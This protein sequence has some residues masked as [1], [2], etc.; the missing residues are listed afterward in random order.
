MKSLKKEIVSQIRNSKVLGKI[1]ASIIIRPGTNLKGRN[2]QDSSST[3]IE[4]A[5]E[6]MANKAGQKK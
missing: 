5:R 1:L 6:N 4:E 2:Q 3:E